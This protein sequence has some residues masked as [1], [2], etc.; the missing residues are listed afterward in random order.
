MDWPSSSS[1]RESSKY[2]S[3]GREAL[4]AGER[5]CV[6]SKFTGNEPLLTGWMSGDGYV[7]EIAVIDD[8]DE[9]GRTIGEL[10]ADFDE[11]SLL[12]TLV[13]V[14][15]VRDLME[16]FLIGR[17]LLSVERLVRRLLSSLD[18]V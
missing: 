6:I 13:L 1:Y 9:T 2:C 14:V 5:Y 11:C 18:C 3:L 17:A 12:L 16:G 4:N 15:L 8:A 10:L 7:D